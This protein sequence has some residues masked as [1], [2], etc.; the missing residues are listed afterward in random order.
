LPS[1]SLFVL[2]V[3][4]LFLH[5]LVTFVAGNKPLNDVS[6]GKSPYFGEKK[7]SNT[8][9]TMQLCQVLYEHKKI[10]SYTLHNPI[11]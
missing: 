3:I 4:G 6:K 11:D 7:P 1:D 8:I 9:M 10:W 5:L 2:A